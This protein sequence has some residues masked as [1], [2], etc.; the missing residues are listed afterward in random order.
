VLPAATFAESSGTLIN[1]EGRAQRFFQLLFPEDE[2]TASWRWLNQAACAL[3]PHAP[4]WNGL[5]EVIAAIV[6][7]LPA[8][9]PI[10]AA[11]PDAALRVAGS[12][13]ASA[14]PRES[15]RTAMYAA[16]SVHEPPPPSNP[17]APYTES[18]EG[19]YGQMPAAL[20]PFFWSPAWNSEQGLN[21]FQQEVGG[22]LRG[23]PAG[24]HIF[25][26]ARSGPA[27]GGADAAVG[28]AGSGAV[29]IPA[30]FA[31]RA[32][33][34]L[35]IPQ[36]RVFGSDELSAQAPAV[37]ERIGAA[38]LGLNPQDA[39]LL[40]VGDGDA[41]EIALASAPQRVAAELRAGLV[42]GVA[43]L[44]IGLPGQPWAALP[45]WVRLARA[46]T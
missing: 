41:V 29:D 15:G 25:T 5:D 22:P 37:A 3:D 18:M 10:R 45:A 36:Y 46:S 39:E 12:R 34:W 38:T 26:G 11:A 31:A 32:D 42:R 7:E 16:R 21:K 30:A 43:T 44:S 40:G 24:A 33:Q 19:Y 9:A 2:V 27:G 14:P 23:G 4:S 13:I 28:T 20:Y 8:L 35:L 6:T 17:D 1:Y